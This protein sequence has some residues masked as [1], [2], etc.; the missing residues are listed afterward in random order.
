MKKNNKSQAKESVQTY[1][2]E[3]YVIVELK[4]KYI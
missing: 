2:N 3:I 4:E 1:L